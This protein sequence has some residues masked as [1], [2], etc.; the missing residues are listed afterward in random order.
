MLS[1]SAHAVDIAS[2]RLH[3]Q[4][5]AT[6]QSMHGLALGHCRVGSGCH[7]HPLAP[8]SP[9]PNPLIPRGRITIDAWIPP[10]LTSAW[11]RHVFVLIR[12]HPVHLN[13]GTE[14]SAATAPTL[15]LMADARQE[16]E[17][18]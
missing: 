15:P 1:A 18:M 16:T 2:A 3:W 11:I 5:G 17:D 10:A 13:R 9:Q 8:S 12:A 14:S 6:G 4:P 7:Y